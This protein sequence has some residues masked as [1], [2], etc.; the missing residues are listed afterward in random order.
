MHVLR[1]AAWLGVI[2]GSLTVALA[3]FIWRVLWD[4]TGPHIVADHWQPLRSMRTVF[5]VGFAILIISSTL[6]VL[7]WWHDHR[8]SEVHR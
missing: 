7:L 2:I 1:C 5:F 4:V 8:R 6:V 3:K